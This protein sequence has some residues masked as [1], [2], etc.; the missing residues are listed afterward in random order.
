[1]RDWRPARLKLEPEWI[2]K[3]KLADVWAHSLAHTSSSIF[4]S[5]S[6][7]CSSRL[8][9]NL[10]IGCTNAHTRSIYSLLLAVRT[11][12]QHTVRSRRCPGSKASQKHI[13]FYYSVSF[14]LLRLPLLRNGLPWEPPLCRGNGE[15]SLSLSTL[16]CAPSLFPC[17]LLILYSSIRRVLLVIR[18]IF[19][20][21]C[22]LGIC[23]VFVGTYGVVW[24]SF[25]PPKAVAIP[26]AKM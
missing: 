23:K 24:R 1:M 10:R 11:D 20:A 18:F 17:S 2:R 5:F 14:L 21:A 25:M 12:A 7:S 16:P 3:E 9:R 8:P 6:F 15:K 26:H 19:S 13:L 4:A 22:S